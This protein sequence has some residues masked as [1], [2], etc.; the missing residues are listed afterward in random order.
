MP[1][2]LTIA[3]AAARLNRTRKMIYQYLRDG[4]LRCV[5]VGGRK[6]VDSTSVETFCPP[7][8]GMREWVGPRVRGIDHG[9]AKLTPR[10]VRQMRKLRAAGATYKQLACAFGVSPTGAFHAVSGITWSHVK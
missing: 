10:K 5:M 4:D 9:Q 3:Q 2:P 6:R 7:G 8:R 1:E